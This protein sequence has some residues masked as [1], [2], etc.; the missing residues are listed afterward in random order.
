MTEPSITGIKRLF[1]NPQNAQVN[2]LL[3]SMKQDLRQVKDEQALY[4]LMHPA[5]SFKG[6]IAYNNTL[7]WWLVAISILLLVL[8]YFLTQGLPLFQML[9]EWAAE[10]AWNAWYF[11][12]Q[13]PLGPWSPCVLLL[14]VAVFIIISRRS[15]LNGLTQAIWQKN[16]LL[17]NQLTEVNCAP[18]T[19]ADAYKLRFREFHRG[20]HKQSIDRL[21]R[22]HHQGEQHQFDFEAFD[23]HYVDK[24]TT[25]TTDSKGRTS[26]R[27]TYTHYHRYGIILP[28]GY[29]KDLS[30]LGY[31]SSGHRGTKW[32]PA[33]LDFRRAFTARAEEEMT[34]ARFF[35]PVVVEILLDLKDA[36]RQVN[37]EFN[38]QGD[39]CITV[40]DADLLSTN[41][42]VSLDEPQQLL[43][44]LKEQT[45]LEK[46]DKLLNVTHKLMVYND[47][48]F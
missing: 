20:N 1:C 16:L 41:C 21:Y 9:P 2:L 35:K 7:Q 4:R 14:V 10:P 32:Q 13:L 36:V 40:A 39:L 37:L 28:F 43:K 18:E 11:L 27:T 26:T 47:S 17:D 38:H 33:S 12:H 30:V 19:Q 29:V 31:S 24:H 8:F 6:K 34:A 5:L 22:G 44:L 3:K 45:R 46:L 48:N 15:R 25:T 23:F 42:P